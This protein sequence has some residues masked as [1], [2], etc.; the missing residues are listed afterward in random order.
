MAGGQMSGSNPRVVV[1]GMG[2]VTNLG[3]DAESTWE[4]M[5][6]GRSGISTIRGAEFAR[7]EGQWLVTI[8]GQIHDFD[9]SVR[10]AAREAHRIDRFTQLGLCATLEAVEQSGLDFA[11]VDPTRCGVA[12]GSGVGGIRTIEQGVELLLTEGPQRLSPHTVPR[13]M[14]NSCAGLVSIR[15]GLQGPSWAHATACSSSGHSLADAV[16]V[17]QRREADVMIAGGT[18]FAVTPVCISAFMRMKAL[19]RRNDAPEQAS[20]P[21]DR[22]RDG[23]VLAEGAAI[24]VLETLEHARQRGAEILCELAGVGASSDAA[25]ITAPDATGRGAALAMQAAL[26]HARLDPTDLDYIN[27]HG[28][29]TPLGD[30]AEVAAVKRV[31]GTT[32]LAISSTKSMHGHCLGA[33]GGVET[34][35]CVNAI[36]HGVVPPTINCDRPDDGFDLDFVPHTARDRRVGAAMNNTFGFGGH[37]VSLVLRRLD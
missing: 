10:L 18:E 16:H 6:A 23:F 20:R 17:I 21:F 32:D 2:A 36:R 14:V 13:L 37:N 7:W 27:A 3:L 34:I 19:S 9:P 1:T 8:G 29:S 24:F 28:T 15:Y 25:H 22:D 33:S 31:F 26:A 11:R 12:I 5:V 4:G 30:R 35:A